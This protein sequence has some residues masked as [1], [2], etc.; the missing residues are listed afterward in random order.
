VAVESEADELASPQRE[1]AVEHL[2]LRDVADAAAALARRA[3]VD[4]DAPCRRL[5]QAEQDPQ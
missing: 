3:A 2:L 1:V 4:A 5:E